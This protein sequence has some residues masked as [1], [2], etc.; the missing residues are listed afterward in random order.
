MGNRPLIIGHRGA[1]AVAPENTM[2]A[3]KAALAAGAHGVEFDVRLSVDR[4]LVVIHDETL[5]RTG[6]LPTRVAEVS[7]EALAQTDVGGWFGPSRQFAGE[8]VPRLPNL[9]ELFAPTNACLYLEMKCDLAERKQ[10]TEA[11]CQFLIESSLKKRV[12][13]E[14]FDLSAIELV[15]KIDSTIR[16]AALFEPSFT[17]PP[18][19]SA[20]R[21]VDAAKAAGADEVALHHKLANQRIVC[22][23]KDAGFKVVVWTVDD[24][25]WISRAES[26][27]IDA[28]ITNDPGRMLAMYASTAD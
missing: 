8:T 26:L 10:L 16:T 15:K 4:E 9:F 18:L 5:K 3:F 21:I 22:S 27:A 25:K 28:L 19:L 20:R 12:V 6:G 2:A 24:P 23:A 13:V 17:T 11:C 14:C 1:A 7:V